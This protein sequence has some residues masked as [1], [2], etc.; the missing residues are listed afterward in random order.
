MIYIVAHICFTIILIYYDNKICSTALCYMDYR[1]NYNALY[2]LIT[3]Y[4]L[5]SDPPLYWYL[6]SYQ[7]DDYEACG[8]ACL[9]QAGCEA[10]ALHLENFRNAFRTHCYG[11]DSRDVMVSE[12]NMISGE[13]ICPITW[14][15]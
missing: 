10:F 9:R 8:E 12:S 1:Q 4:Y 14:L 3:L 7:D 5:S 2:G 11:R 15:P 6:G 13:R